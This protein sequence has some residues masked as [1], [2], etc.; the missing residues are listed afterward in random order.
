[1]L[2]KEEYLRL[3]SARGDC[4]GGNGGVL[5]LLN[6][7]GKLGVREVTREEARAFWENPC[8]KWENVCAK[9]NINGKQC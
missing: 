6:W 8:C 5:D 4:Y 2:R 9:G 3:I 7:C 1:M